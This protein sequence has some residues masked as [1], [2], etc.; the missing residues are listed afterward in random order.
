MT[1]SREFALLSALNDCSPY[2]ERKDALFADINIRLSRNHVI[3]PGDFKELLQDA[4]SKCRIVSIT[5]ED[6]VIIK[7]TDDG[8]LRL[9][10]FR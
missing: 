1:K 2:G 5:G 7:I 6:G 10:D 8:K 4:E 3:T 9:A